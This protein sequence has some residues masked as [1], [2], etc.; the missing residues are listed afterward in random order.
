MN[1]IKNKVNCNL[2]ATE[3]REVQ[4][5]IIFLRVGEIDTLNE[6]FFAEILVESKWEEPSLSVEFDLTKEENQFYNEEKELN[7]PTKYWN[8]KIYIENALNDPKQTVHHKIKKE[9]LDTKNESNLTEQ[10]NKPKYKFWLYEYRK[11]KGHF[12]EKL[13]LDYFPLDVQDLSI[14]VTT[15]RSN[16]EVNL[17]HNKKKPSIVNSNLTIDQNIWHL[18]QHVEI[19]TNN[20]SDFEDTLEPEST[21]FD[22][23][24][25]NSI[26]FP[27][28]MFQCRAARRS[29]YYFWNAY[30]LIFFITSAVFTTF[31]IDND[32]P[33]FRLP[34]T[35]TLLLTSITFRWSYSSRCLPTVNYLTSL[36]K[37]SI[38]S[39]FLI[40]LTLMWHGSNKFLL[41]IFNQ[42]TVYNLDDLFL[43]FLFILFTLSHIV[44]FIWLKSA[45]SIRN[46]MK[47]KDNKLFKPQTKSCESL[48]SNEIMI[49]SNN[50]NTIMN[51]KRLS[52]FSTINNIDA[53]N[54]GKKK[55]MMKKATQFKSGL[56]N[57]KE[58]NN[59]KF[60]SSQA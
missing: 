56:T 11:I 27:L 21:T 26:K 7:N 20:D 42:Q 39:L 40:F 1:Q 52:V 54:A 46:A 60:L 55:Y 41:T 10:V 25:K 35:A 24:L 44:L 32:K 45:N 59:E 53:I 6:K 29:G 14:S 43:A 37:Y 19:K 18:Y 36:D 47:E 22:K 49:D 5:R 2:N 16:K 8:P 3:S 34:T 13:E 31:S 48:L 17:I 4:I 57:I 9:I 38:F 23:Y 28:I 12:F 33:H 58:N 30:I 15:F 51:T 50:N